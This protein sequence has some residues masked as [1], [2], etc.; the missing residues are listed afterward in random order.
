MDFHV[1]LPLIPAVQVPGF[2]DGPNQSQSQQQAHDAA[3][4]SEYGNV[5]E[6]KMRLVLKEERWNVTAEHQGGSK[7]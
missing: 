7:E 5:M 6:T 1:R 4:E 3:S 2:S